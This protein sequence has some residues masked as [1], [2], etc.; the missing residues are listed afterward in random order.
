MFESV[1]LIAIETMFHV[2]LYDHFRR[3]HE[4]KTDLIPDIV[5]EHFH[6]LRIQ[7]IDLEIQGHL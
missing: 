1:Y 6:L 2:K 7:D 4:K 3:L 5:L